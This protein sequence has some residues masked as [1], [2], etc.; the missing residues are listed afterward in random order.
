MKTQN[1][2]HTAF[3]A[4]T[5]TCMADLPFN[6]VDYSR[7]KFGSDQV[8]RNFGHE[9]AE[10]FFKEHSDVLLSNQCVVIPSPYNFVPNAATVMAKHF[11]NRLN[12]LLVAANGNHVEWSIIHRKVTY[13]NDYGFL[14]AEKR[15]KLIDG[16]SFYISRGFV[17]DK[18]LI[19]IDDVKITGTH[20]DKLVDVLNKSKLKNKAMF[21]YYAKYD[22]TGTGA[23]IEA[24]L[25]FAGLKSIDDYIKLSEEENHHLIVRPIKYLLGQPA[26]QFDKVFDGMEVKRLQELYDACLGEGYYR[27][28]AY[29]TNFQK[30]HQLLN[31]EY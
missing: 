11:H 28:P 19:F 31:T 14:P 20:E 25:N 29:Q 12:Q 27:I 23:D 13:T 30:L 1:Q 2:N 10:K 6:A 18:V 21:L 17:K 5:F 4:N 24:Q 8:A 16:D 7:L 9:L 22:Y 3:A 15:R 26:E